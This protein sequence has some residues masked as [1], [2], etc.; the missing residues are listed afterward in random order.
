[1]PNNLAISPLTNG[2]TYLNKY[3]LKEKIGSGSFGE[4]WLAHDVALSHEFALKI[5]MPSN[6]IDAKLIEARVGHKFF[7][8]NLVRVHQADVTS[9]GMV[10]IA[11]DYFQKGSITNLANCAHFIPLNLAMKATIDFLRGLEHL[12]I[13]NFYH[14]DIKPQNILLG[15][16]GQA[17]LSDYGIVG[18]SVNGEAVAPSAWYKLHAA[19]EITLGLGIEAKTDVFQAGLTF[20]RLVVGMGVLESKMCDLGEAGYEGAVASGKLITKADFPDYVPSSVR[21]IILKSVD[22]NP[23]KRYQSALAMRRDLEKLS[24]SGSWTVDDTGDF[25][26]E[27]SKYLYKFACQALGAG[28]SSFDCFKLSKSSGR[29]T[30]ISKYRKIN[31]SKDVALA[32]RTQFFRNVVLGNV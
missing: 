29:Q 8:N 3:V 7:H 22:P 18:S 1:M 24:F 6:S 17:K 12:H 19:P 10:L 27:D 28:N 4:V 14:N 21:S 25:V 11:M 16:Q 15:D 23:T 13:H 30:K 20:F 9:D 26:G 2:T 32:M 31:T 5:L